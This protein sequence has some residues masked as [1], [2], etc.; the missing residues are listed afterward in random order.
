[1]QINYVIAAIAAIGIVAA[2]V[3][4]L[5]A[6]NKPVVSMQKK[7][8]D[9]LTLYYVKEFFQQ[10]PQIQAGN[11]SAV[12]MKMT[13]KQVME[14]KMSISQESEMLYYVLAIYDEKRKS[15]MEGSLL[16][17]TKSIDSLLAKAF[18]DKDMLVLE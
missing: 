3:F 5:K 12:V 1:M 8:L 6:G 10:S 9:K 15:I 4:I 11:V 14:M 7:T 2:G 17:E 18:G 16:V 13:R